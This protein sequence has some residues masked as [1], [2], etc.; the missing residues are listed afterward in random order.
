MVAYRLISHWNK[1]KQQS[2]AK[3][4]FIGRENPDTGEIKP[5]RKRKNENNSDVGTTKLAAKR[6]FY[7]TTLLFDKIGLKDDLKNCF[8]NT[9]EQIL[10]ILTI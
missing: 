2:R 7:G 1:E 8:L 10:S 5:T 4:T 3:I 6:S 9:Y